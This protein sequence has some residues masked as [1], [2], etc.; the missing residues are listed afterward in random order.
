MRLSVV[1]L[2]VLKLV[3]LVQPALICNV[4]TPADSGVNTFR[5]CIQFANN[6][7]DRVV[8]QF[9]NP[10]ENMEEEGRL[11]IR[12]RSFLPPLITNR[13]IIDGANRFP[14]GTLARTAAVHIDGYL[15][16]GTQDTFKIPA[17]LIISGEQNL[18]ITMTFSRSPGHGMEI[19]GPFTRVGSVVILFSNVNGILL[20][21]SAYQSQI[22]IGGQGRVVLDRNGGSGIESHAPRVVIV[23]TV[24]GSGKGNGNSVV[25]IYIAKS[26]KK[27]QLGSFC[28]G[29]AIYSGENV[30][31][32][33]LIDADDTVVLNA[34][35]GFDTNT[36]NST[37]IGNG[38]HGI[39][40]DYGVKGTQIGYNHSRGAV[41]VTSSTKNGIMLGGAPAIIAN[42]RTLYNSGHGIEI[43]GQESS[44]T[45]IVIGMADWGEFGRVST[46]LNIKDGMKVGAS[47]IITNA[48][49]GTLPGQLNS[50]YF[51]GNLNDGISITKGGVSIGEMDHEYG[52]VYV[53]GNERHGILVSQAVGTICNVIINGN[54]G[55]GLLFFLNTAFWQVG[56][57][58]SSGGR[59]VI[60][61][62]ADAGIYTE[63]INC[64]FT[65]LFVG[66]TPEGELGPNKLGIVLTA[67]AANVQIGT[68]GLHGKVY[69]TGNKL[70][71][72]E[73]GGS[74]LTMDNVYIGLCPTQSN[75]LYC[76]K[77][78]GNVGINL[79]VGSRHARIALKRPVFIAGQLTGMAI[80]GPEHVLGNVRIGQECLPAIPGDPI[81][82]EKNKFGVKAITGIFVHKSASNTQ[83]GGPGYSP[84]VSFCD[85]NGVVIHSKTSIFGLTCLGNGGNGIH[86]ESISRVNVAQSTVI[87]NKRNGITVARCSWLSVDY[88]FI[89]LSNEFVRAPNEGYGIAYES[90]SCIN[91]SY[92]LNNSYIGGNRI[93]G[94]RGDKNDIDMYNTTI[95][96]ASDPNGRGNGWGIEACLMCNCTQRLLPMLPSESSSI[97]SLGKS[98]LATVDCVNGRLFDWGIHFP[99]NIPIE[100]Q[101]LQIPRMNL[102][103][104]DWDQLVV[105]KDLLALDASEN[106]H[107][108]PFPIEDN[109]VYT[110]KSFPN[111][112]I[113]ILRGTSLATMKNN[114]FQGLADTLEYL[115]L[116]EAVDTPPENVVVN[117][118]GFHKLRT[119]LWYNYQC[120]SGFYAT[121]LEILNKATAL[122]A[123]CDIGTEKLVVG[124]YGLGMCRPC[125]V[126][127]V[128]ADKDP[129]TPCIPTQFRVVPSW[130][131]TSMLTGGYLNKYTKGLTY[132]LQAVPWTKSELFQSYDGSANDITYVL[133]FANISAQDGN[134][135]SIEQ[136]HSLFSEG[137]PENIIQQPGQFL[138]GASGEVLAIPNE[139]GKYEGALCARDNAGGQ[140]LVKSWVFEILPPDTA[141]D[142]N[143]P[144]GKGCNQGVMVDDILL[145]KSFVCTC[146]GT[147][148]TG[149]NCDIPLTT[150]TPIPPETIVQKSK[151]RDNAPFVGG[152]LAGVSVL[153]IIVAVA[154]RHKAIQA[155]KKAHDF[156]VELRSLIETG[157]LDEETA[158]STKLPR[159][160]SRSC[161]QLISELGKGGF[162]VVWKGF[163]DESKKPGGLPPYLVAAKSSRSTAGIEELRLEAIVM[164]QVA[165]HS[166]VVSLIGVVSVGEP[167]LV[168][169]SYCENGSLISILK[170][171]RTDISIHDRV[172]WLIEITSGMAHLHEQR[173]VHRDLAARNILLDS[174]S[175][176]KVADFGLSRSIESKAGMDDDEGKDNYYR[177]NNG[178]FPLRWTSP[179][180][181]E[182]SKFSQASDCWSFGVVCL[183][184]FT[185]GQ[186]PYNDLDNLAVV[187]RIQS[188]FRAPRPENCP[189][190]LYNLM[191]QCWDEDPSKR[192]YFTQITTSLREFQYRPTSKGKKTELP[193][194]GSAAVPGGYNNLHSAATQY[195]A[196]SSQQ[197]SEGYKTLKEPTPYFTDKSKQELDGMREYTLAS[198]TY[199]SS[200]GEALPA[201]AGESYV[202][203]AVEATASHDKPSEST[204]AMHEY[205]LASETHHGGNAVTS[206]KRRPIQRAQQQTLRLPPVP[207][208]SE[209]STFRKPDTVASQDNNSKRPVLRAAIRQ[210]PNIVSNPS[211][212]L[213][214]AENV[215]NQNDN[216]QRRKLVDGQVIQNETRL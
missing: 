146:V 9:R 27:S 88:S 118:T 24:T 10:P 58:R 203:S 2:C 4:T 156:R 113:L 187:T 141:N 155:K 175:I 157:E 106:P 47:A 82:C 211:F 14:N 42:V 17:L 95:Y 71:G 209:Y 122:C 23:N 20:L 140:A 64:T 39:L 116:S 129:S 86:I 3:H 100:T 207:G 192:P 78:S 188:G 210:P 117:L 15:L 105:L 75:K 63:A 172:Q 198:N 174:V 62:N 171:K 60:T 119:I 69:F 18:V 201:P 30:L 158:E 59:V 102:L 31:G 19:R 92:I 7:T 165:P 38:G 98:T 28:L 21:E 143:G 83:I 204:E 128:D 6:A 148:F 159:E 205:H 80:R 173:F 199:V 197:E 142:H 154:Y 176:C 107:L 16:L 147:N 56:D 149:E 138:V 151:T 136:S 181:M 41:V 33:I 134:V 74:Y 87:L 44:K 55:N 65:N 169:V 97:D 34:F 13:N 1:F 137:T 94:V 43:Y 190:A 35:V 11:I 68:V 196:S 126:G 40:V 46:Y 49:V 36:A 184:V 150:P 178:L 53:M 180:A 152:I 8:I 131:A 214:D 91:Q 5:W 32:G 164:A 182:T 166:N 111:L 26:G 216:E 145:D 110:K 163:L 202:S 96:P 193:V 162:G 160:I 84:F 112:Q 85:I 123:K 135:S 67:T 168:L 90:L 109:F 54:G 213:D 72:V 177:S 99:S 121:S 81:R 37:R 206:T 22:G 50:S 104:L 144:N 153:I 77:N 208:P 139:L 195:T 93:A 89:G 200:A 212:A 29:C 191:L 124:G 51:L 12:L 108:Q 70:T 61:N 167:L 45:H 76:Q 185:D 79:L 215:A 103:Q 52:S 183:E 179:E 48:Y 66:I 127:Y 161:V 125:P 101:L 25:G 115:D 189:E 57:D 186:R 170:Q 133:Q 73:S 120:P 132:N 194:E 130:N 114:S